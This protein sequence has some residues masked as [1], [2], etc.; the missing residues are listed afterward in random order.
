MPRTRPRRLKFSTVVTIANA[1]VNPLKT[2][3]RVSIIQVQQ[4]VT[5]PC[6][7]VGTEIACDCVLRSG[8]FNWIIF[9]RLR[10]F[11]RRQEEKK[12][13]HTFQQTQSGI[14]VGLCF[15]LQGF[16]GQKQSRGA[17]AECFHCVFFCW[18]GHESWF[19]P[20]GAGRGWF[21]DSHPHSWYRKRW[22]TSSRPSPAR[23]CVPVKIVFS[24]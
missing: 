24:G 4:L 7:D 3:N 17:A 6:H 10:N 22:Y 15:L 18:I 5:F 1:G 13:M 8:V 21:S 2:R 9:G 14:E 11:S 20:L 23:S 16:C 12:I 19:L